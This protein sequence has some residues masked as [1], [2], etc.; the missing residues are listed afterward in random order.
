[1]AEEDGPSTDIAPADQPKEA[2]YH[3]TEEVMTGEY[4]EFEEQNEY[5]N[6]L[7]TEEEEAT[8][9]A[10]YDM[11]LH[12]EPLD[13]TGYTLEDQQEAGYDNPHLEGD[14]PLYIDPEEDAPNN[15][16]FTRL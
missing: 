14:S 5:V 15:Y 10:D 9:A 16:T 13:E 7:V 12:P 1:V 4:V 11:P 2:Q 3:Y 8:H 6:D